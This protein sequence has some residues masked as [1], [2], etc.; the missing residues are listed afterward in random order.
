MEVGAWDQRQAE[1]FDRVHLERHNLWAAR[2]FCVRQPCEAERAI[3]ISRNVFAY[4][5]P[6]GL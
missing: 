6:A 3:E 5:V 4:R 2:D 1:A